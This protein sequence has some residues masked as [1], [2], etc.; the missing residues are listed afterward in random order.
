MKKILVVAICLALLVPSLSFAKRPVQPP[1]P[2]EVIP[3]V[4]D[5]NGKTVGYPLGQDF[6]SMTFNYQDFIALAEISDEGTNF[7]G[8]ITGAYFTE[9]LCSGM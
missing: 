4:V 5:A 3:K 6:I 2:V 7:F 8:P 9:P 1:E